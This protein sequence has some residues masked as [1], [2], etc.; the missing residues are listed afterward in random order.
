MRSLATKSVGPCQ[1]L[2]RS[3]RS[4]TSS[5]SC[6]PPH[7]LH[8][9]GSILFTRFILNLRSMDSGCND[10]NRSL[11]YTSMIFATGLIHNS[12]ASLEPSDSEDMDDH[13]QIEVRTTFQQLIENPSPIDS[14][15]IQR[16]CEQ[17]HVLNI[18]LSAAGNLTSVL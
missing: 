4:S 15:E 3:V 14:Q 8:R 18:L 16:D 17:R 5:R 13:S 7:T 2:C 10:T 9:F 11:H 12:G 6:A 1:Q